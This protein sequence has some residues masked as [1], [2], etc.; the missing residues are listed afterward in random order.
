M[1]ESCRRPRRAVH[2]VVTPVGLLY[3]I[4]DAP[5][6]PL[7]R[8]RARVSSHAPRETA[9]MLVTD[10]IMSGET[11]APF[12]DALDAFLREAPAGTLPLSI[13]AGR[14]ELAAFLRWLA[15]LPGGP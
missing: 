3:A 14:D 1:G 7:D 2:A 5:W 4:P 12:D 8:G 13:L 6:Y 10:T 15:K 11:F 9:S